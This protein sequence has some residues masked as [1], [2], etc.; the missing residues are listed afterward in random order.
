MATIAL[1]ACFIHLT[2]KNITRQTQPVPSAC[3]RAL[4]LYQHR[5]TNDFP[6]E[7]QFEGIGSVRQR[8]AMRHRG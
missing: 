7:D 3:L 6:F 8:Y 1:V 4:H 2:Q 5:F